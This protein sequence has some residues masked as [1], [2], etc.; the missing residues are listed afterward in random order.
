MELLTRFAAEE[1]VHGATDGSP[2][3][4]LG[5][6]GRSF[7]FQ[8][9]TFL[10]V[11]LVLKQFA[12][13]PI[14]KMLARRREVIDA[15]VRAGM[16]MEKQKAELDKKVASEISLARAEGD[17]I[18]ANA[19][20]EARE[21]AR[22]AEKAAHR[23]TETMLADAEARL[24]EEARR[25]KQKLEKDIVNLVSEATEAIVEEKVDAKKD[26]ALIDKALRG[27]K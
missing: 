26:S 8:L 9:I 10:L 7:L 20:K 19:H 13:K 17:K 2:L 15:G 21:I 16:E 25:A 18:I 11:F 3:A 23:K 1:A 4:S 12:F 22:E 5:I 24:D 27:K 14:G 6:D